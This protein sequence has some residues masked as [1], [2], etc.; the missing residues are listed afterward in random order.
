MKLEGPLNNRTVMQQ[1]GCIRNLILCKKGAE[2]SGNYLAWTVISP[3][4]LSLR[5]LGVAEASFVR[6]SAIGPWIIGPSARTRIS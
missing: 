3:V 2:S 6:T 5:V 1:F 4:G